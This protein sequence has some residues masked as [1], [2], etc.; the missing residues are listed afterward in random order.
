VE[1]IKLPLQPERGVSAFAKI[2]S[3]ADWLSAPGYE[4]PRKPT[5]ESD[6]DTGAQNCVDQDNSHQ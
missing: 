2:E 1:I 5:D 6:M 3:M 4:A